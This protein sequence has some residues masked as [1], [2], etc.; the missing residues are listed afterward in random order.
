MALNL[1]IIGQTYCCC[2]M[3][4]RLLPLTL[5]LLLAGC[6]I[7]GLGPDPRIAL[8]EADGK[9]IGGACRHALRGIEDCYGLNEKALK[10][11]V[12]EGWKAMDQYMRENKID[13]VPPKQAK[14][15][16]A[17]E[18]EEVI[19]EDKKPKA[20]GKDKAST[21]MRPKAETAAAPQKSLDKTVA[22]S[23]TP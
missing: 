18:A 5:I 11:A 23:A 22:K 6:E 3:Y 1:P 17:A 12:F 4:F 8:R 2:Y 7:P 16:K 13:G 9:A 20:A 10:T 14:E 19:L 15:A 21:E